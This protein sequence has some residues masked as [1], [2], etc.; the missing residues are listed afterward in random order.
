MKNWRKTLIV[1]LGGYFVAALVTGLAIELVLSGVKTESLLKSVEERVP[2][3]ISMGDGDFDLLQWFF[4]RP[5]VSIADVTIGNPAG[6]TSP[7]L[8]EAREVSARFAL[9]SLLG[10]EIKVGRT[11]LETLPLRCTSHNSP[12]SETGPGGP[13]SKRCSPPFPKARP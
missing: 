12:S 2:V 1:A 10:D 11:N 13:I 7:S 3:P 8:L 6:F 9:L 5:T 4:F